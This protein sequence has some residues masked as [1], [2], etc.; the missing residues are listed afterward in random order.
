VLVPLPRDFFADARRPPA[1]KVILQRAVNQSRKQ[2][3]CPDAVSDFL[4]HM[5]LRSGAR[6]PGPRGCI[7]SVKGH[8][9]EEHDQG[10]ESTALR[11]YHAQSLDSRSFE[12][13]STNGKRGAALKVAG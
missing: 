12:L 3:K 2:D 8:A 4:A 11:C 5:N 6:P 1:A 10:A 13:S 9:D 7:Q